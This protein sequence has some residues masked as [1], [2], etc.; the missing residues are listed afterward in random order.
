M[1]QRLFFL[2]PHADPATLV[3]TAFCNLNVVRRKNFNPALELERFLGYCRQTLEGLISVIP[4]VPSE[5]VSSRYF[6]VVSGPFKPSAW[7][8]SSSVLCPDQIATRHLHES[9]GCMLEV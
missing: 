4:R 8:K 2:Q 1:P 3:E 9:K 7:Q 6:I 5:H